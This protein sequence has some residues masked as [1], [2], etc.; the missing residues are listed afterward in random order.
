MTIMWNVSGKSLILV[1]ILSI[2]LIGCQRDRYS[3]G[4]LPSP[5]GRYSQRTEGYHAVVLVIAPQGRGICTGTF[6]SERAVLTASHCVDRVG[7]YTVATSFGNFKTSRRVRLGAGVVDDPNDIAVLIFDENVA[8]RENGQ[9]Y[10][11]HHDIR[12]GDEV[13]LVGFGCD[14]IDTRQGSGV[15]RTGTNVVADVSDYLEF[16]TPKGYNLS[17]RGVL[18]PE[19]RSGSCYG[20]SGGPALIQVNGEIAVVGVT[21]AGGE[22]DQYL[23]SEYINIATRADNRNF[24]YEVDRVYGLGI[25]GI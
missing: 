2:L 10:N 21:H 12:E 17:D 15:K 7:E 1:I 9:V 6:I 14:N 8:S 5:N 16:I 19:N 4:N 13:R 3:A 23:I 20:D 18:G 24:L 25:E 22:T 11:V